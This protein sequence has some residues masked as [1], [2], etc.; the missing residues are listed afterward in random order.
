MAEP[1]GGTPSFNLW[2]EPWI[3][4]E[5]LDGTFER[6]GI[7][8]VLLHAEQYKFI[9]D[10]SPLAMVGIHRLLMAILQAALHPQRVTDL[11]ALWQARQFPAQAVKE[12]G[13]KFAE[14]FDLFSKEAP[15]LQSSDL[16]LEADK[17]DPPVA[18][19][20]REIP[21]GTGITHYQHGSEDDHMLCSACTAAGLAI[22]PA[23]TT[24][25]GAGLKPSINGVPP[26]YVLPGG[27]SLC[28][29]LTASLILPKYQPEV[30]DK[31]D[32]AWWVRTPIVEKGK[33][34]AK[35]GYLHSLTFPARRV[36]LHPE[37]LALACTRCG[38]MSAWGV[39]TMVFEMGESRPK[40]AAFWF[41]PFAAYRPP[42][43]EEKKNPTPI[44]PSPG[45]ALWREFASLFLCAPQDQDKE[46]IHRP[47]VIEQMAELQIVPDVQAFPFRCVGL[48]TDMKGKVFEWI[49]S[50]F[51]VPLALLADERAGLL[52]EE[53]IEF[54]TDC[55]SVISTTFRQVFG[56]KSK[57]QERYQ[58]LKADMQESYWAVLAAPFRQFILA[59]ATDRRKS[60][61][62]R[63]VEQVIK[64]AQR[65]FIEAAAA[66]GDDA[67]SLRECVQG[68]QLVQIRLANKRK[69]RFPDE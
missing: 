5:R 30:A 29:S 12:F 63:W 67:A 38:Q 51:K 41:D 34:L 64:Q 33:E 44:R 27:G 2:R 10:P 59:A 31:D 39:R 19:L 24:S 42:K 17:G 35:V 16:P 50:S 62:R 26:I 66:V 18:Y 58:R 49:D 13:G 52:V 47:R 48:R 68:E 37:A 11:R 4:V 22:I 56:G 54:A 14:R 61:Q 3:T 65:S 1:F 6:L 21:S 36:R 7:E 23:F 45:K 69:E 25:G 57:K 8:Q 20:Y 46:R 9:H 55:A 53:G 60:A 28:E 40:D 15:F 43:G 32:A